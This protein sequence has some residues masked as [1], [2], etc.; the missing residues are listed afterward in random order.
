MP[1]LHLLLFDL[2]LHLHSG[3]VGVEQVHNDH[4]D[5]DEENWDK[6]YQGDTIMNFGVGQSNVEEDEY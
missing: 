2:G 3:R 5:E 6:V 1:H 4:E